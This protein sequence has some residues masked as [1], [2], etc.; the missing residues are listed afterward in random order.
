MATKMARALVTLPQAELR[1]L[2]AASKRRGKSAASLVREA[3][4]EYHARTEGKEWAS[5][6]QA[7]KGT[8]KGRGID[9]L[10][11]VEKLRAEWE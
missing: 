7:V 6:L 3:V 9:A 10:E 1:W 2:K 8:W 5:R 11:Y 4:S